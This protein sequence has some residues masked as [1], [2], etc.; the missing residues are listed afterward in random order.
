MF[1]RSV[2]PGDQPELARFE[3]A[4][5]G[6]AFE[7][8]VED[9]VRSVLQWLADPEGVGREVLVLDAEGEVVGVVVHEDDDGDR[10]IN[11]LAIRADRQGEGLGGLVL[12]T[13]LDDLSDRF[14]GRVAT[15][16]V[17]PANFASH[18]MSEAAG[19]EPTSPPETKPYLLYAV[20]L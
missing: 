6:R 4:R 10:F 19:A 14:P 20:G 2:A 18:A 16:L 9:F 5:P 12:R 11:A 1:L 3:C 8:E 7:T 13:L 15:W 17:A